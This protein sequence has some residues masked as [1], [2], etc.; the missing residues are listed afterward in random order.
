MV[1]D[2]A[3][4]HIVKDIIDYF[5][6]HHN[7]RLTLT[8]IK[9]KYGVDLS[10]NMLSNMLINTK[11]YGHHRGNDDY[12]EPYIDKETFDKIQEIL[13][14]NVKQTVTKRVYL[15]STLCLCPSCGRTLVGKHTGGTNTICRPSG[16]VYF[17]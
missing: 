2:P 13:K 16:K 11:L 14:S 8:Y 5:L 9:N 10:Y 4:Q 7:K 12:C 6:V 17:C 1:K 3:T 15:F